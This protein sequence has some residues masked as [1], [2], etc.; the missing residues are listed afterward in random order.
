MLRR[1][2][3]GEI[4]KYFVKALD[5]HLGIV[6]S[7]SVV[8]RCGM[9]EP[10]AQLAEHLT[11]NQGARGSNPRWLTKALAKASA[12]FVAKTAEKPSGFRFCHYAVNRLTK[13]NKSV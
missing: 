6:Y 10:L 12:F 9:Y 13:Q 1:N 4:A 3:R 8:H 5:K 7:T 2:F 11:F